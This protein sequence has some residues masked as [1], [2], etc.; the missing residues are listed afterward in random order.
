MTSLVGGTFALCFLMEFS[1]HIDTIR[2]GLHIVYFKGSQVDVFFIKIMMFF[3][4]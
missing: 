4:P 1:M 3:R 2:M